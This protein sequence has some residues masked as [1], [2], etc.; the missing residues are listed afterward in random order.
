MNVSIPKHDSFLMKSK[1][2][3]R[4]MRIH[5]NYHGYKKK[6]T[7]NKLHHLDGGR[8]ATD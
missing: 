7:S 5:F 3:M 4:A 8:A 6:S 1:E 2:M